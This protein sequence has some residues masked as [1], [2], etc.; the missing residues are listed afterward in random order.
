MADLA[1][2]TGAATGGASSTTAST[3]GLTD[4]YEL[5]L[6]L[7]TTQIQ[8]QDPL[9]PLDSAEYT[10]QLVQYSSVEQSI[11]T[12][13]YLE[14]MVA[15]NQSNQAYAYVNYLGS[16][17]SAIGSTTTLSNGSATWD[18]TADEAS[19][20]TVEI[21]NTAGAV[22]YAGAVELDAGSGSYTWDG[23]TDSGV[24][25]PEGAYTVAFNVQDGTGNTES[26]STDI[27]GT[28]D[29]VDFTGGVAFLNIGDVRVPIGA[30]KSVTRAA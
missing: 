29:T 18:Y 20:G 6:S 14:Q 21:R 30:V 9:D 28:V 7:L 2:I 17:V 4:N 16:E 23:Q 26:I 8:N 12:N 3:T 13:K 15:M 25:A 27:T 24:D 5:F 1:T 11:Q 19:S 22:V 10:N